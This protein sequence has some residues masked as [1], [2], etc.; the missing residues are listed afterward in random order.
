MT[1][2]FLLSD[3][4]YCTRDVQKLDCSLDY[5][6]LL[7]ALLF[8]Y[9]LFIIAVLFKLCGEYRRRF[10]HIE[11]PPGNAGEAAHSAGE[12]AGTAGTEVV[13]LPDVKSVER[14]EGRE[15]RSEA[16]RI[17]VGVGKVCGFVVVFLVPV[18]ISLMYLVYPYSVLSERLILPMFC[19][20]QCTAPW[21]IAIIRGET[22]LKSCIVLFQ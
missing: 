16:R 3:C 22:Y 7:I 11:S 18:F 8:E 19:L 14:K 9:L 20:V 2:I 10:S 21:Y 15:G 17:V 5:A 12:T 1:F 13:F 4:S 6:L